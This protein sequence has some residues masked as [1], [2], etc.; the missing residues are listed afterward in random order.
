M[1]GGRVEDETIVI[2]GGR[3]YKNGHWPF[4]IGEWGSGEKSKRLKR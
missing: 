3:D 1:K 2:Q 4:V